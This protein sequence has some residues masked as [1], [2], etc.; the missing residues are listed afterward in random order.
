MKKEKKQKLLNAYLNKKERQK[1]RDNLFAELKA[2]ETAPKPGIDCCKNGKN[3]ARKEKYKNITLK[4]NTNSTNHEKF[5]ESVPEVLTTNSDVGEFYQ[6]TVETKKTA[7]ILSS[8]NNENESFDLSFLPNEGIDD[9]FI[10]LTKPKIKRNKKTENERKKLPIFYEEE[11]IITKIKQLDV[12][13]VQGSTGCGKSTQIPQFIYESGLCK[14]KKMLITQPRRLAAISIAQRISFELN[15]DICAYEIRHESTVNEKTLIKVVTEGIV[16]NEIRNDLLLLQYSVIILDEVHE[17]TA[18][19]EIILALLK[20]IQKERQKQ[21]NPL[22]II[23]MSA[24]INIKDYFSIFDNRIG[25]INVESNNFSVKHYFEKET[26]VDVIKTAYNKIIEI[27]C[28]HKYLELREQDY[29][30]ILIFLPSTEQIYQL[31]RMLRELDIDIVILPLHSSLSFAKQ[32]MIYQTYNKPK[33]IV[34]TNMAETSLTIPGINIVIDTGLAKYKQRLDTNAYSYCINYISKSSA[35]QRAG[36]AGRTSDGFC[37]RLYSSKLYDKFRE[38]EQPEI[39]QIPLETH[40]LALKSMGC[41]SLK[42]L[43]LITQIPEKQLAEAHKALVNYGAVNN[44]GR[45]TETGLKMACLPLDARYALM[46]TTSTNYKNYLLLAAAIL[47]YDFEITNASETSK[48]YSHCKSDI[49]VKQRI[50]IDYLHAEDKARFT[51]KIKLNT[52]LV[53]ETMKLYYQLCRITKLEQKKIEPMDSLIEE[54]LQ[55][56]FAMVFCDNLVIAMNNSYYYNKQEVY[57]SKHSI[58]TDSRYLVFDHIIEGKSKIYIRNI[59]CADG[60][61][62]QKTN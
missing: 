33:I 15:A 30:G 29:L 36:R 23:L 8:R 48:Y 16:L 53:S 18:N 5:P 45:I 11:A 12:S 13:V 34:S 25:K 54:E 27:F 31:I 24:D 38:V 60:L 3:K 42:N 55:K 50:I 52:N 37:F 22:K 57:L 20:N 43:D 6:E 35:N 47:T 46:I 17:K 51:A 59:T 19:M 4:L 56:I 1:R 61:F 2:Y 62:D 49:I 9:E 44:G 41:S 10:N 40:L 58:D 26:T 28:D 39:L 7:S 32:N 21:S 14:N